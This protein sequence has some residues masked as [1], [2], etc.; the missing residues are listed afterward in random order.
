MT[1]Q[2]LPTE[3]VRLYRIWTSIL[4]RCTKP[5]NKQYKNYGGRGI[6]ICDE[7]MD[8]NKFACDIYQGSQEGLHLDRIDNNKGYCKENCRWASPKVN[9]RNKR[10]NRYYDTHIGQ[11]CQSELIENMGFTRKQFQ[12][13][14]EKYGENKLLELFKNNNLPKKR[15]NP[16]LNDIL[17]KKVNRLTIL[18]FDED[19]T[20]GLRYYCICDCG[21][22]TRISRFKLVHNRAFECRSCTKKG[23]KNPRRKSP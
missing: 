7:W 3:I 6:T 17:G 18:S 4:Y 20:A 11:I 15:S 8:F 22:K 19:K 12:R 10:N 13:S 9:H 21:K 2:F 1:K 5:E 14:I 16:N 23:D